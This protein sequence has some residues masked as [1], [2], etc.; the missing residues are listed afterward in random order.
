MGNK[1]IRWRKSWHAR[2][3]IYRQDYV[4]TYK[5]TYIRQTNKQGDK[6]TFY[7]CPRHF[8]QARWRVGPQAASKPFCIVIV[9]AV[10]AAAT[11]FAA[12]DTAAVWIHSIYV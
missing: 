6:R 4:Q 1:V 5:D 2:T 7:V 11:A 8:A 10:A 9:A 12:A 3:Y